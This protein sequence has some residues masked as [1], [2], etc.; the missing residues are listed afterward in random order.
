MVWDSLVNRSHDKQPI[1]A[2]SPDYGGG[3]LYVSN[4]SAFNNTLFLRGIARVSPCIQ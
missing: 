2:P 3:F 1:S 4:A